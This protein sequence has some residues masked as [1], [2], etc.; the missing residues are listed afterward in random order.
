MT[1]KI[2]GR[3]RSR[4]SLK[5][6]SSLPSSRLSPA[7]STLRFPSLSPSSLTPC[8]DCRFHV[9]R[10]KETSGRVVVWRQVSLLV[11]SLSSLLLPLL[12]S[13]SPL[14]PPLLTSH[15][16]TKHS[17][18]MEA[19]FGGAGSLSLRLSPVRATSRRGARAARLS[20]WDPALQG[21]GAAAVP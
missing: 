10:R 6:G 2:I 13:S 3:E 21:D 7:S 11:Q 5:P 8:Q 12:P 14:L 20:L 17:Y 16:F 1:V 19:S 9:K 15:Q 18:T 4:S